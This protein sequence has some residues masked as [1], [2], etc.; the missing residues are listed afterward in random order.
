MMMNL[1]Q[2]QNNFNNLNNNIQNG[3]TTTENN[4]NKSKSN[5]MVIDNNINTS[6]QKLPNSPIKLNTSTKN[7]E[8][9]E[10][11]FLKVFIIESFLPKIIKVVWEF[12]AFG[13]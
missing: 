6:I 7:K 2:P 10:E 12:S 11:S 5:E 9:C 1:S 8:Y 13:I 4:I 3:S